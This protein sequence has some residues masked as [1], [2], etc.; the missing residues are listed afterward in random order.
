M[1][2]EMRWTE[3]LNKAFG[4]ITLYSEV[5]G[6]KRGKGERIALVYCMVTIKPLSS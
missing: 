6:E 5:S 2:T 1:P 3:R 4:G